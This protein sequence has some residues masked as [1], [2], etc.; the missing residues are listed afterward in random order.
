MGVSCHDA[1]AIADAV[2]AGADHVVVSPIFDVPGKGP[3]L[4]VERLRGLA[5][6][7]GVPVVALG[8]ID[9]ATV[10]AV[11]AAGVA[12][13][14]VTRALADAAEPGLAARA[15]AGMTRA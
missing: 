14:A 5:G 12:G 2:A 7:A 1:V 8:G 10:V 6:A 4:G 11:R 15:L 13:V 3:A 9:R